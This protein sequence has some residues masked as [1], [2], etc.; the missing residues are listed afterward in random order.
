MLPLPELIRMWRV[1]N[2]TN[3]GTISSINLAASM[4]SKYGAVDVLALGLVVTLPFQEVDGD[5]SVSFLV[6]IAEFIHIRHTNKGD[7]K[8]SVLS[9]LCHTCRAEVEDKTHA[10]K[11]SWKQKFQD[12]TTAKCRQVGTPIMLGQNQNTERTPI[13]PSQN[14]NTEMM[15]VEEPLI[16]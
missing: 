4:G 9:E 5:S 2:T 14:Q 15:H 13:K 12:L 16:F 3:L 6:C 11:T 8:R 7:L 10:K 1:I